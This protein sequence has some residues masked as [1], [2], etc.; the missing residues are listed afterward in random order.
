MAVAAVVFPMAKF[1]LVSV[2]V[3]LIFRIAEFEQAGPFKES[4]VIFTYNG[5]SASLEIQI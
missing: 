5:T 3:S 2:E 4:T 1:K